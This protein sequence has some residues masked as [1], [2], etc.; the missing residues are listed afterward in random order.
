MPTVRVV[1]P[2]RAGS[3]LADALAVTGWQVLA[4][5]R[6]HQDVSDAARGVDLC[7]IA[8]PDA[9][10]AA[11]A[12]AVAPHPSTV[13]AHLAGSLGAE[14]LAPHRPAGRHHPSPLATYAD[15]V[16]GAATRMPRRSAGGR[17]EGD[18]RRARRSSP[19]WAARVLVLAGR[20]RHHRA[21]TTPPPASPPTTS[22]PCMAQ[23]SRRVTAAAGLPVEALLRPGRR[24]ADQRP[25]DRRPGR[26]HRPGGPRGLADR[27]ASRRR[28]GRWGTR[29]YLALASA[30]AS[31]AGR[32]SRPRW[33]RRQRRRRRTNGGD[34]LATTT[35]ATPVTTPAAAAATLDATLDATVEAMA[36]GP[37]CR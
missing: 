6:R 31:L 36:G 35:V 8:T 13:V 24:G 12:A 23:A 20:P 28:L 29:G 34:G 4:P 18:D 21:A 37:A 32:Q 11:T 15:R 26:A 1:G 19:T 7:V 2:G 5:V 14:V 10:I 27:R 16:T 25:D 33:R 17:S 9:A 30:A 22:S 3:S